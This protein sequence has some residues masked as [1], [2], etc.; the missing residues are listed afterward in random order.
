MSL[1]GEIRTRRMAP[2]LAAYA[3]G[4]WAALELVDQLA[5]QGMVP[6]ITYP[7]VLTLV[8]GCLPGAAI[9]AWYHGARG[10]Q[11]MPRA[12]MVMLS[13]VGLVAVGAA[14]GVWRLSD[15]D[16]DST[17]QIDPDRDPRRV[18]VL[19]FDS[20]TDVEEA[21]MLAAGLTESLIDELSAVEALTVVSRNGVARFRGGTAPPDS[22]GAALQVGTI[23]SGVVEVSGDRVRINVSMASGQT[24]EQLESTRLEKTRD[25]LF[26]LQDEL[27]QEVADFLRGHIG[28]QFELISRRTAAGSVEAWELVQR[29]QRLTDDAQDQQSQG[30]AEAA[31]RLMLSAD[32]VLGRAEVVDPSWADPPTRRGWLAYQQS[33][34]GGFD[35]VGYERWI[36]EGLGHAERAL[37]LD[38]SNPDALELRGTLRY[39]QYLLN[40]AGTPEETARALGEAEVDLRASTD[41]DPLQASAWSSLS[42]LLMNRG[43]TAEGKIAASRS[44]AADPYLRSTNLTLWR[45]FSASLDLQD[46]VESRRW[47]DE[48]A[49]RFPNDQRFVRCQVRVL[50]LPGST[51]DV[52]SVWQLH[53]RVLELAGAGRREFDDH[54]GRMWIAMAL[55]RAEMP[56]SAR[57]VARAARASP[58]IDPIRDLAYF[59]SIVH[60]WLGDYDEAVRLLG[61][62]LAAN[63]GT[64]IESVEELGWWWESLRG[65]PQLRRLLGTL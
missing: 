50:A 26:D 42:H 44:Y 29:A 62:Y 4:A 38:G 36:G 30:Q 54:E 46:R 2:F 52:D 18:A 8:L 51:P 14:L 31:S 57:A 59:E 32:S 11:D 34:L 45:L 64:T 13:V 48:G 23:V 43:L 7:V 49:R 24:G 40:I 35:R 56:D 17:A 12:E 27:S 16:A 22:V 28:D 65:T 20:R 61:L 1:L 55:V 3:G 9:V 5:G 41:Y 53:Q 10:D 63:P 15:A 25:E 37:N 47:C 33:R 6:D 19:Y 58:E 60:T 39:W 21:E